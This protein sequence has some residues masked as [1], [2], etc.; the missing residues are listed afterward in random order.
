M[1]VGSN[2]TLVHAGILNAD[3]T[4]TQ[5]AIDLFIADVKRELTLGSA[6]YTPIFPCGPQIPANPYAEL[7]PLEDEEKFPAFHKEIIHGMYGKVAKELNLAGNFSILPICDPLALAFKL[8]ADVDLDL[9]F[10]DGFLEYLIPNLPK[11]AV[12]MNLKPPQLTAKIPGLLGTPSV[13]EL[14]ALPLPNPQLDPG[15]NLDLLFMTKLPDVILSLLAS[16]PSLLLKLAIPSEFFGA[17]CEIV[18]NSKLFN[19]TPE[20]TARA[21]AYK[22]LTRKISE[23]ICINATGLIVGSSPAGLT[24]GMGAAMG[25]V[26][27]PTNTSK[28]ARDPRAKILEY[29]EDCVD[30]EWGNKAAHPSGDGTYREVYTQRLL[31]TEYGD[32]TPKNELP[33]NDPQRDLRVIGRDKAV[34]KASEMSSCGMFARACCYFA[35]ASYYFKFSGQPLLNKNDKINRYYDFFKD[36]Y[37][38]V[39][40]RGIAIEAL[41]QAAKTK[42]AFIEKVVGDLPPL[43]AGDL[44]V[45]YDTQKVGREHV[46]IV[47]EDYDVGS[48][49]LTTYEGGQ[50]DHKNKGRPTAIRKKTYKHP[51]DPDFA[52]KI[53]LT[54]PPYAFEIVNNK[55]KFSGRTILAMIDAE[56]LCLSKAGTNST[57][58]TDILTANIADSNDPT[59]DAQQG[60]LPASG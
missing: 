21:V 58:P 20:A 5:V 10:P 11:L 34:N 2:G 55:V 42:S 13:P 51:S 59:R 1:G 41:M 6:G 25:Y 27:P 12:D 3:E 8:G 60:L 39:G 45:V 16:M 24:G 48:L 30:L 44:I 4:L 23:M 53:E 33:S 47:A 19:V 18:F 29:A 26:P 28:K 40:G 32:G 31:Y 38:L 54:D 22:I 52:N 15:L 49:S 17:I 50:P 9:S 56:K 46:M 37:R 35:G 14:P 57:D 7:L 43:K 36:E